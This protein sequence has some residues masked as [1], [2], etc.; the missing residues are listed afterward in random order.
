MDKYGYTG[1]GYD[2]RFAAHARFLLA[3]GNFGKNLV[4]FVANNGSWA[5]VNKTKIDILVLGKG[6][7]DKLNDITVTAEAQYS[8]NITKSKKK[9]VNTTIQATVFCMLMV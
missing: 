6:P 2:I 8:V 7:I 3:E 4:I 1:Y 9:K 5:H